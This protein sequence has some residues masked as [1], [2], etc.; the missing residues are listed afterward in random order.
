MI[1]RS[2]P[3]RFEK[4]IIEEIDSAAASIGLTRSGLVKMAVAIQLRGLTSGALSLEE[5]LTAGS[6]L[7]SRLHLHRR[8]GR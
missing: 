8:H 7:R 6:R 5:I 3:I 2:I 4:G 1:S